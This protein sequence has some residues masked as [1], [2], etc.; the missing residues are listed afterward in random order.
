MQLAKQIAI[1]YKELED[2]LVNIKSEVGELEHQL[3]ILRSD[4]VQNRETMTNRLQTLKDSLL[5][6]VKNSQTYLILKL[7]Y[8]MIKSLFMF[9]KE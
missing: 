4:L 2:P 8:R 9:L 5:M 6:D 1:I 7:V 3:G